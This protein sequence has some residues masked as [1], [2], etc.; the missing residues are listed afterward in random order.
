MNVNHFNHQFQSRFQ[1]ERVYVQQKMFHFSFLKIYILI[2]VKTH[3]DVH[4]QFIHQ[5]K[6]K[7]RRVKKHHDFEIFS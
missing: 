4:I 2:D 7:S 3:F 5:I 1:F 6:I